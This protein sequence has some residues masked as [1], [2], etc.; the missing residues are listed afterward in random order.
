MKK[1]EKWREN[2]V[3]K[4]K[5]REKMYWFLLEKRDTSTKHPKIDVT[6]DGVSHFFKKLSS[7]QY[8]KYN[9]SLH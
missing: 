9:F 7:H 4:S 1:R 6:I 5:V 2:I 8:I 3:R